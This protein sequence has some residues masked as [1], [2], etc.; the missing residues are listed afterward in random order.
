MLSHLSIRDFAIIDRSELQLDAGMTAL[1]GE[2]GAGKSILLDAL[3]LVLGDR[4]ESSSVREGAARAEI[5]ASFAIAADAAAGDWLAALDFDEDGD[6][7]LRRVVSADGRS[8]GYINGRPATLAQL[9]ELG[10]MLVDIHGQHAH[11]SLMRREVQRELLDDHAG[12]AELLAETGEMHRRWRQLQREYTEL[13]AAAE[14]REQRIDML[15]YQLQ[16]LDGLGLSAVEIEGLD[17]EHARLANAGRL[18]DAGGQALAQLYEDEYSAHGLLSSAGQRLAE[19]QALDADLGE[20]NEL[21][22]G[23]VIQIDEAAAAL[24]DYLGRTELDPRRLAFVEQ[25]LAA[26]HDLARKH[27]VEP[28][29]LPMLAERL[30]D[31][32][33]GL[34]HAD[35]SLA[36]MAAGLDDLQARYTALAERLRA[37]R[38]EAAARLGD[39]VSEYMQALGMAG[40]RL[41]IGV[42]PLAE[43]KRAAH[44]ADEVVFRVSANAG[45]SPQPLAK[46]ASGGELS[47]ISLAIQMIASRYRPVPTMIFDEVDSGIGGGIAEV[48]GRQLRALGGR[49]QA[50]C[51]THLPQVAAQAHNHL[52][53]SKEVV[54]GAT[55]TH[56]QALDDGQRVGEIARMLG[57]VEITA[58]SRAHAEE[59]IAI[60]ERDG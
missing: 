17:A 55:R 47:R 36:Q 50:L 30:R 43:D 41:A 21:I 56:L 49:C 5:S 37:G 1:T 16:E 45:R 2:T 29:E 19:L 13:R 11:Q 33:D 60:A 51:V 22:A 35:A 46:V 14:Q 28:G 34:E 25:Q 44:G 39:E 15:R 59:M 24:R 32:L 12:H 20:V 48:V 38:R 52:R 57:G 9:R 26:L 8:R 18:L 10:E 31:E 6:C 40:G 7:L 27:R 3:G 54:D 4:A 53:V 23:A 42:E 58:Q